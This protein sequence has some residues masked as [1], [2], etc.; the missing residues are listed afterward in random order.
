MCVQAQSQMH[1]SGGES[2][3]QM[4]VDFLYILVIFSYIER[5]LGFG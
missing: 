1:R 3:G 2:L 4:Y 5:F